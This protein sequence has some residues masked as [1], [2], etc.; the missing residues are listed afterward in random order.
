MCKVIDF[1]SRLVDAQRIHWDIMVGSDMGE[2]RYRIRKLSKDE[3]VIIINIV[4][5]SFDKIIPLRDAAL[6]ELKRQLQKN[7]VK[8]VSEH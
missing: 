2:D 4:A 6:E 1:T 7:E 5:S 3:N 8:Y